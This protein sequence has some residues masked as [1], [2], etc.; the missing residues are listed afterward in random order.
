MIAT[1]PAGGIAG[2]SGTTIYGEWCNMSWIGRGV[3]TTERPIE[4]LND[5]T[6]TRVRLLVFQTLTGD[7]AGSTNVDISCTEDGTL[8]VAGEP[9]P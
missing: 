8:R 7:V 6:G 5:Y 1:T 9:C 2:R 3:T 4:E